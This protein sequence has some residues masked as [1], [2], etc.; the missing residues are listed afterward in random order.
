MICMSVQVPISN[1]SERGRAYM[2]TPRNH[3]GLY[4]GIVL[5]SY[6]P[7]WR[8]WSWSIS[9]QYKVSLP[10]QEECTDVITFAHGTQELR[11]PWKARCVGVVKQSGNW[12]V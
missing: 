10:I 8:S 6:V 9:A 12:Y 4:G 1:K 11:M 7:M 2:S 3:Q 5:L